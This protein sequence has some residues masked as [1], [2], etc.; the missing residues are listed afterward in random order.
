[1]REEVPHA[2]PNWLDLACGKVAM[3]GD[4]DYE[5]RAHWTH[6]GIQLFLIVGFVSV[7][8]GLLRVDIVEYGLPPTVAYS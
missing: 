7:A 3:A 2:L 5:R 8:T 4:A 1:M 6:L